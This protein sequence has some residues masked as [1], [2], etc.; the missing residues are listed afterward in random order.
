MKAVLRRGVRRLVISRPYL[1][2]AVRQSEPR[3]GIKQGNVLQV[4][5]AISQCEKEDKNYEQKQRQWMR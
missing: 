1:R 5:F 2:L 3:T 4:G